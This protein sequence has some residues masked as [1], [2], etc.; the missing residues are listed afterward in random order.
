M[1]RSKLPRNVKPRR[2]NTPVHKMCAAVNWPIGRS[3]RGTSYRKAPLYFD[4]CFDWYLSLSGVQ[5]GWVSCVGDAF[6]SHDQKLAERYAECLPA[7][8]RCPF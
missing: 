2:S 8:P 1:A 3:K 6:T 4:A 7:A 5:Q